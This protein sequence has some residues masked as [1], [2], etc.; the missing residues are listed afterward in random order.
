MSVGPL[1]NAANVAASQLAQSQTDTDR[2]GK[3][4]GDQ[5]RSVESN[6]KAESAEGVGETD[7]QEAAGDRDAD[8]RRLWEHQEEAA[9]EDEASEN[10]HK[11]GGS[12]D[13]SGARGN[14]LDLSG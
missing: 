1:G 14:R 3:E 2:S 11:P 6:S 8:G 7:E 5:S 9:S 13:P 12:R 10:A 4:V